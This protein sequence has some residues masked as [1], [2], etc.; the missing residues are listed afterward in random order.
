MARTNNLTR[1][2]ATTLPSRTEFKRKLFV[3]T[4]DIANHTFNA[5]NNHIFGKDLKPC[6]IE[7]KRLRLAYGW[8]EGRTNADAE[9]Y[10]HKITIAP[11]HG[12]LQWFAT[13]LAHEMVHHWQWS[14]YSN[15]R[16][17]SGIPWNRAGIMSHGPSFYKWKKPLEKY[18]ISLKSG[19]K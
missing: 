11:R 3:P 1:I 4:A 10:T 14:I 8:C 17:E 19:Y 5:L 16:Y 13:I 9:F 2:M 18:G 15:E 6:P 12:C 7:F